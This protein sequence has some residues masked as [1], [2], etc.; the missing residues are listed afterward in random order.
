MADSCEDVRKG[1]ERKREFGGVAYLHP[2]VHERPERDGQ[3]ESDE[4]SSPWAEELAGEAVRGSDCEQAEQCRD[5][6]HAEQSSPHEGDPSGR[7]V[8][9][10][11][12]V[13]LRLDE[14]EWIVAVEDELGVNGCFDDLVVAPAG[15]DGIEGD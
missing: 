6:P 13:P 9:I 4:E 8:V 15:R 1:E 7:K 11:R 10:D 5:E 14:V 12:L 3:E 2:A